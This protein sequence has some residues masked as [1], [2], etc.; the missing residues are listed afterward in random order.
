MVTARQSGDGEI[1]ERWEK[2][3]DGNE[4]RGIKGGRKSEKG[5]LP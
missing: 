4:M 2:Q 1:T 3:R 5:Q